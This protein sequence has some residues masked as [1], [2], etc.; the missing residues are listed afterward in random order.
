MGSLWTL[1]GRAPFAL[2]FAGAALVGADG[3]P[4]SR[5]RGFLRSL[6]VVITTW[7][8]TFCSLLVMFDG[9]L[10]VFIASLLLA[11]VAL[12]VGGVLGMNRPERGLP[13]RIARTYIV[14]R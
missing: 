14:P 10:A 8:V 1:F 11:A 3:K 7:G 5:R 4:V 9:N 13:D 6:P 12:G 2:H